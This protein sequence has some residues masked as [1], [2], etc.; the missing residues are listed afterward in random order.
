MN[1][2]A[3]G[4]ADE[5]A[6]PERDKSA[7]RPTNG[8]PPAFDLPVRTL[9][10][11]TSLDSLTIIVPDHPDWRKAGEAIAGR[12][13][14]KWGSKV[15][16]ESAARLPDAWSGNT[17]LVG[18]L[19]NNGYLSKLY[20]MKYTYADAIYPGKGGYQ[21]QTLINPFGLESNTV[22][23]AASDLAGLRKGQ[24]RLLDLLESS[25]E[26][27]L[28][29]LNEAV[30]SSE[31][32]AVLKPLSATDT[33][34]A[35]L[36][37]AARSFRATLTVLSDAGLIGENYFL[38]GSE[39]AGA[40]YKKIMLGFADF[41]N[42]YPKEAKAHLKQRENIWTAGHSFFAAWYVNEPS[43][44][45]TDEERK[46]IVSAVYV[47]LD[48][49]GND[50][51]IPRHSQKFARNNHETYPAFSLMTGAF[52]FRSHYPGLLPEVDSWYAIG[53]QM[54]TNNTAVISRDDGS[55]YMMHV[56]ITTL[57]YALMTG[58]RRFLREGMRA[59]ADL[60]AIM[61]DNLGVMVGGGDVVPF[62]RSSAYH[63]GHS[64]I[65]NAAAW[66]YGDPSY[67]LLLERTRSGP[68]PN[69]AMGDLIRPL[70]RYATDMAQ[71]ET[72]ASARTSLVSGYPVD[73]GVYGDLAKEMKEDINVPQSE[74]FHKLGFRQGY[75]P[76]DS[77]LL[78][79]G[80][81]AGAHNHHDA[82]TFLRYTDKGRIFI[83][84]RDY[85]ERGPEHKNGIVV[86]K[87]GVQEMKPKLA[88]VDWLGDADGMAVSLT[89]LP[90]NNGTDWQRAVISPGGRFY[91][92]YDQ[93]DFKQDGSYV[94]ENV[95]QTLG[96]AS[97]KADRFEVEQQ[98]VTMTLQSMDDSELRTYDRY[99]HFQ[100]YYNRKTPY[101]YAKE[102]NVLREVKE[103]RA[104]RAGESFRFV[105]VL[106][107]STTDGATA[108]AERIDDHT[109]RI[110][111]EGD[112]WLALWGRSAD[113]GEFRSDGGLYM[114]NGRE[115]TVAGTTRVEFGALSLSFVQPVLFKLDAERKTWKAFA[116]AKGLVQ[117]DGQGN[118]LTEGIVQEGTH[119]LDR[120]A[121]RRLKEQL[122][123][124]RSAP[125][126][127]RTFTPDKSPEGWEKR[128]SFDEAVS[129]SA[130]GDLDGDGIEELVVGGVNG[131]VRAFR[132]SGETLWT[133]ESRGRVNEVTV[134][135]LDGKPVVTVASENWNV[136]ILEADGSVK[137]TKLVTTTQ[138]PSHG[139]LIGVTNIRIAYVDGQEEDP[140]IMVG[141][142]FNNLIGLDRSGKQVYSEEAYYYGIEDMQFAD[143]GGNGKHM[144]ILGME[145]VY[146]AIFKEKAPILRAVRDT[147]PGWKAVRTFPAYKNGPAAAVLGSKENRV[148]LARF[149]DNTLKDVWMINV[150]GEVN[151]I[152]VNDF[153]GDGKTEIIAGS[154]GHQMYALDEDGRVSWRASIG[155]R[156][157]KVNA[158]R[159][160]GG[161]RYMAGADNGKLVTLTSD[162][163]ME[164]ATRFSSDIADILVND[165]LDQAWVI[166]RN[167]EVYVR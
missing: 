147:G 106:S 139:N 45:F 105:N 131:K 13:V 119:E 28:R 65:L 109:M 114:M 27:R 101:F 47:V 30:V 129:G 36:D 68:F 110:R 12:I 142:S 118:P 160:D 165:K 63:W 59:S 52:Y 34:L 108:E 158:L 167:G 95:W 117:Y 57:D 55:D 140:W 40:Q 66:F 67:R 2:E 6:A 100:Q 122:E 130:L 121:V 81:G 33:L 111:E 148:H 74:S 138:T 42:R 64:A 113:T 88:R 54:F 93:I 123:M 146:P 50:G 155:D 154:G 19:G 9:K 87:D 92:I 5:A 161:V 82:N 136:H 8:V 150:G 53:E 38:T 116:V 141:T 159:A 120:E 98:G 133:Y 132:H 48:A 3:R 102:E 49:N 43:P 20:A 25:P 112:E 127:K 124:K 29:W 72:A 135:Q 151:D 24:G 15:K 10:R 115:L 107:S 22:I 128:I 99:G 145:Y 134:Q 32:S 84:A 17:I 37:P 61:I 125:I 86:V 126:H 70:H 4:T 79:D 97:V 78:I 76:E 77:Y 80:T 103:E 7:V 60:Q 96:N 143:F 62:G 164:S 156:V 91:L 94:L 26:P 58:D 18:N 85:I 104:Y 163:S 1:T 73:S 144:G 44:I 90:D 51:Y 35:K 152:Q 23:L 89:T 16:L 75:G 31:L 69:Q 14:A 56:P 83:D 149:Q 166:L 157:L 71:G 153:K 21:L 162:G 11:E 41:L 137:W 46:R 39:A